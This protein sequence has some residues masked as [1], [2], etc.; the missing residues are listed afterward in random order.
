M[1]NFAHL[2][3]KLHRGEAETPQTHADQKNQIIQN[4]EMCRNL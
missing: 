4:H 1:F 2:F 3:T